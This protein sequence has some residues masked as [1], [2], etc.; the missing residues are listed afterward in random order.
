[1]FEP[2]HRLLPV[3]IA[4][5]IFTPPRDV[6]SS[7]PL[8][9]VSRLHEDSASLPANHSGVEASGGTAKSGRDAV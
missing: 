9:S 5:S 3:N 8:H 4:R 2:A 7:P 6:L 1:M